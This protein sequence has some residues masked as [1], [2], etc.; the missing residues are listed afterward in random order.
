MTLA[1]AALLAF[2]VGAAPD[3]NPAPTLRPAEP[4]GPAA[5]P[6]ASAEDLAALCAALAPAERL[7]GEGNALERGEAGTRH[8]ARRDDALVARYAITLPGGPLAF[9]PYDAPEHRLTLA[10]PA[11]LPVPQS[12]SRLWPTEER[13]LAVE[14]DAAAARRILEAQRAGRLDLEL[15][16]DLPEDATCGSDPRGKTFTLPVEPVDWRWADGQVVL[17]RGGAGADRPLVSAAQGGR[18]S[19]AVGNPLAGPVEARKAVM[20][21]SAALEGCYAEALKLDPA[22]DGVLVVE[23]GGKVAVAADST[24]APE[25]GECVRRALAS[26][27][28]SGSARVAVPIRFELLPPALAR[29]GGGVR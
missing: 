9:A 11:V 21:R 16:F 20:A 12:G 4:P 5:R 22:L 8:E 18:P 17:A 26:L 15:V 6:I 2:T 3:G 7:R 25:L 27:S 24:G 23:L 14:V 29:P 13:G 10:E 19:V 28:R 1:L